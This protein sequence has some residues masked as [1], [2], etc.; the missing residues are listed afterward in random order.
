MLRQL[1]PDGPIYPYLYFD[2]ICGTSTGGLIAILLG[3]LHLDIDT[4]IEIYVDLVSE[5]FAD[6]FST[7]RYL[8][9]DAGYSRR[10]LERVIARILEVYGRGHTYMEDTARYR[11]CRVSL[12][13]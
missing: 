6:G 4:A 8:R 11:D 12:W 2:L 10:P 7:L 5:V 9:K 13:S 3:V 1:Q